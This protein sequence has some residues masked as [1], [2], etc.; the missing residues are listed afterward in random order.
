MTG[1]VSWADLPNSE[2]SVG[3]ERQPRTEWPRDSA[4]WQQRH[5]TFKNK[6]HED[7]IN[8]QVITM[9]LILEHK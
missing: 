9:I 8:M 6:C 1:S 3:T 5:R 4:T 7:K 2:L